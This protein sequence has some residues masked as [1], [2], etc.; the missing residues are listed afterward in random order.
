MRVISHAVAVAAAA[1]VLGIT[2][3]TPAW[4][5]GA[6]YPNR[7]VRLVVPFPP[8]ASNDIIARLLAYKL[9]EALGQQFVV[10]N[11]PGAGGLIGGEIVVG[12]AADG[13]TLLFANPAP[14]INSVLM[15]RKPPYRMADFTPVIFIGYVPLILVASPSFPPNDAKQLLAY[16]KANPGKINWASSGNG[17]SLH[18]GLALFQAATGADVVH[19][20]YKGTAPALTDVIAGRVN[21]MHTTSVSAEAHIKAGKVKILAVAAPKRQ[22]VLPNV[23]TLAEQGIKNAEATVWFGVSAPAKTPQAVIGKLN[24]ELNK[25]LGL[26]D[27]RKRLD[28]LGLVVAGGTPAE[29]AEFLRNEAE[30]M[31]GL[32][33]TGRVEMSN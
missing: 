28:E 17:S 13:H 15:S 4:S 5:Q 30:K 10:D 11:R 20:P 24:A 25:A 12:A 6:A 33:K 27:V 32:I 31:T 2:T 26:A 14:S 22:Q 3:A 21:L 18:I 23:P 16:A 8:G 7:P 9:T 29:F 19:V 1:L